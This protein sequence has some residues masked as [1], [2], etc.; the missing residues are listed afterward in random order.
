MGSRGASASDSHKAGFARAIN[1]ARRANSIAE[2][3]RLKGV[4]NDETRTTSWSPAE[5]VK[6]LS[7]I[8]KEKGYRQTMKL[9]SIAGPR[10]WEVRVLPNVPKG[11]KVLEGATTAPRGYKWYTNGK[12]RFGDQYED[13]LIKIK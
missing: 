12:S 1:I 7:E 8:E 9:G 11:W 2:L 4:L 13:A 3:E 6:L 10:E 5:K